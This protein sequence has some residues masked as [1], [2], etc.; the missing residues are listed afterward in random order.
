MKVIWVVGTP[1]GGTSCV[2]G[3]LHHLGVDM[4]D[5][6]LEP[7]NREYAVFE[8]RQLATYKTKRFRDYLEQRLAT[9]GG[10]RV[11]VKCGAWY[12]MADPAPE[13]LPVDVVLVN[14]PVEDSMTSSL[15]RHSAETQPLEELQRIRRL[16]GG[17]G[18]A[19]AAKEL[20]T[21]KVRPALE[22][23]FR[24]LLLDPQREV[25]RIAARLR[26]DPRQSQIREAADFVNPAMRHI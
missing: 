9:A 7:T 14:R 26:L 10:Q 11:G 6:S 24:H 25:E 3:V 8:D 1:N 23:S 19:W 20:L 16:V 18:E 13:T 2:A 22:V 15:R 4:G 12:W 17:I 5:I 21:L